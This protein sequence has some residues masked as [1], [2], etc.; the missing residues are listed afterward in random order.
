MKDGIF[1]SI[2][3]RSSG[4]QDEENR[5]VQ[6]VADEIRRRCSLHE[7]QYEAGQ[8]NARNLY[9][10]MNIAEQWAKENDLWI[11]LSDIFM[12]GIPGPSGNENDTYISNDLIFKVN[13]LL[14]SH[15][16]TRFLDRVR[17][18]N[19]IFPETFYCFIG[20]TGFEGSTVMPVIRQDLVKN[21][22]PATPIQ[23]ETYMC[24]LGFKKEAEGRFVN[25]RY[26]VW[27]LVPRNVLVDEEGDIFVVDAE[28]ALV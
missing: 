11:P 7:A 16:I 1:E 19:E 2:S 6:E 8:S 20:F 3:Q 23:I 28:I 26:L 24:A 4:T 17:F 21:A 15:S 25:Q 18:H 13:N 12:I 22:K 14:N 9:A 27:D 10:E 5:R